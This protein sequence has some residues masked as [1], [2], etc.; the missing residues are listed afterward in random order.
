MAKAK[1]NMGGG[2]A[3]YADR[4]REKGK[5]IKLFPQMQ[6]LNPNLRENPR[7]RRG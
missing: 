1:P 7:K 5:T 2:L 3:G 6:D 4:Q